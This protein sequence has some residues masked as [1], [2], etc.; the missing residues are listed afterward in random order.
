[1]S[2]DFARYPSLRGR[3]VFV[4]GGAS[5]IGAAHVSHFAE[6]GAHV[7]FVDI[8]DDAV[9][10]VESGT[11][12]F[13]EAGADAVLQRVLGTRL[14]ATTDPGVVSTAENVVIVIGTPVD[15]HLN[16]DQEAPL[17]AAE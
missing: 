12:P 6:Q 14:I 17:R 3:S 15:E 7:A 13:A 10:Q 16:P 5:G 8:N 9:A 11:M 2:D 4:T 1:M